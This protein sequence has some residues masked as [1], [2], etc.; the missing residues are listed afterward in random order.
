MAK[1]QKLIPSNGM[2]LS[3]DE[4]YMP[5]SMARFIKGWYLFINNNQTTENDGGL[6][7]GSNAYVFTPNQSNEIFAN[8]SMANGVN[9]CIGGGYVVETNKY[10]SCIYNSNGD[11]SIWQLD[12]TN[13]TVTKV[14]E[15]RCFGFKYD[16]KHFISETRFE[17]V[18]YNYFDKNSNIQKTK[19]WIFITDDN[20]HTK[21]INVEDAI[22]T[23][24]FNHAFFGSGDCCDICTMI[25]LGS[26]A[27]PIG[28][29]DIVPVPRPDTEEEKTKPN[30][31]NFRVWQFRLKA[32]DVWGRESIHGVI[33]KQYYNSPSTSCTPD[34]SKYPRLIDSG[35][36]DSSIDKSIPLLG[37]NF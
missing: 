2:D 24:G 20:S 23:N 27:K 12:G 8:Q 11:D 7:N 4:S 3:I 18:T 15:S 36:Y 31:L 16:A 14:M 19:T 5:E 33:S 32:I 6:E 22:A 26:P 37:I 30:P 17:Y 1:S 9:K 21:Q 35:M 29:I 28:C 10:Y 13:R 25:T 34:E